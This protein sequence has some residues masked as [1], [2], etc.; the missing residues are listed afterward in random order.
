MSARATLAT[1]T[2]S[3]VARKTAT[4]ISHPLRIALSSHYISFRDEG[5]VSDRLLKAGYS[6]SKNNPA[7]PD[8]VKKFFLQAN[9]LPATYFLKG[10]KLLGATVAGGPEK[11]LVR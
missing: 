1:P 9:P 4:T 5:S 8:I 7:T 10:R 3:T 11:T 6:L 2:A